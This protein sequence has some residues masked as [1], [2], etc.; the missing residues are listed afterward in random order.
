MVALRQSGM[1]L[2]DSI[3]IQRLWQSWYWGGPPRRAD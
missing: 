3:A 1:R 2:P